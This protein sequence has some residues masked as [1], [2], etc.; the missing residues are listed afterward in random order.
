MLYK[1]RDFYTIKNKID[2]GKLFNTRLHWFQ[3]ANCDQQNLREGCM[4]LEAFVKYYH[5]GLNNT[6]AYH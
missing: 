5:L 6:L 2:V 3:D 4:V 1:C